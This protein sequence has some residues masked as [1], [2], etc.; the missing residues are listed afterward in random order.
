MEWKSNM[1]YVF[2]ACV[3]SLN[4]PAGNAHAPYCHLWPVW[5]YLNF[6]HYLING[7]IF[8]KKLLLDIRCV[9]FS[10]SLSDTYLILSRLQR[11]TR[12]V[13]KVK[14]HHV[15]ADREIYAY[16]G[17]TAVDLDPLPVSRARLTVLEPV[18][19]EWD[20]FE[21]AAPIQSPA[22]CEVR[23][24]IRFLNAERDCLDSG[25]WWKTPCFISSHNRVQK[26]ISFLC[27]VL[28]KLE[29]GTHPFRFVIVR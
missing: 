28:E 19:F 6:P 1:Y 8:G 22:K 12:L 10:T 20:V 4:Y 23:S 24:V 14:I 21:M 26:L 11:D 7:K 18:L 29:R 9:I 2:W 25:V 17:N 5:M 27:V 13:R 16:Y 3:C 15:Y